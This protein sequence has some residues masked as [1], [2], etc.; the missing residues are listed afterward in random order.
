MRE[1]EAS[2][3][4]DSQRTACVATHAAL[5]TQE[6]L[7]SILASLE[8]RSIPPKD[9]PKRFLV[10]NGT[11]D[12]FVSVDD[13]EWNR[14]RGLL[15]LPARWD[16]KPHAAR[17]IKQLAG[18]LNPQKFVRIH[19]S[20]IVNM[21]HLQEII[22]EGQNEGSVVLTNGQRLKMSKAGWQKLLAVSRT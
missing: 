4:C 7:T 13:I 11:K 20:I 8:S 19:R 21:D 3:D 5:L 22:R 1:K 18:T 17:E 2:N 12:L 6:Q 14:G 10:H 15:L 16:E 9:H